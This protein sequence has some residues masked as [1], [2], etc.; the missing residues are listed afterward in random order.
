M[1][2]ILLR[3]IEPP[4]L[5]NGTRM[6][7]I[8]LHERFATCIILTGRGRGLETEIF[9]LQIKPSEYPIEF[10]RSQLPLRRA[11]CMTIN[12]SQGVYIL[13]IVFK[14]IFLTG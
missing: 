11:G 12:K 5:Y 8:K 13:N 6:R 7:V 1:V 2:V 3:T 14:R 9:R 4:I 10:V